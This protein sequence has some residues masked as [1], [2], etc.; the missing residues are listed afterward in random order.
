MN[1]ICWNCAKQSLHG[2]AIENRFWTATTITTTSITPILQLLHHIFHFITTLISWRYCIDL[3]SDRSSFP[4]IT[5]ANAMPIHSALLSRTMSIFTPLKQA[6]IYHDY[7]SPL[8][9]DSSSSFL[10][11]KIPPEL[12][13]SG[14][15][16]ELKYLLL[17]LWR[18]ISS[19]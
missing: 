4:L 15:I 5:M 2:H 19:G 11:K 16:V 8:W 18:V 14:S 1:F 7:H 10:N 17:G 6:H 13:F 12:R 3:H 9:L